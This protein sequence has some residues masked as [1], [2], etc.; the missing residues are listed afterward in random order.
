[1]SYQISCVPVLVSHVLISE[2]LNCGS[3]LLCISQLT[4]RKLDSRQYLTK[5]NTKK[6]QTAG[7]Q[8]HD[9][10]ANL[11]AYVRACQLSSLT[12]GS[13]VQKIRVWHKAIYIPAELSTDWVCNGGSNSPSSP[14][15]VQS[16]LAKCHVPGPT[17]NRDTHSK[18]SNITF[19]TSDFNIIYSAHWNT[20]AD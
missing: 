13:P 16:C 10:A 12:P 20:L 19:E 8:L 3:P 7:K 15:S 18:L 11:N 14:N 2:H 9:A 6:T 4:Y 1:M 5:I 17:L